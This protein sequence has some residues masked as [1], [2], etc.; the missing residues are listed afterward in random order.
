MN[1]PVNG[2]K[3]KTRLFGLVKRPDFCLRDLGSLFMDENF[4]VSAWRL[5][6][7]PWEISA[8]LEFQA[9]CDLKW[10]GT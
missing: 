8:D 1:K 6:E 2:L 7:Y 5:M 9:K 4:P 10:G 3:G